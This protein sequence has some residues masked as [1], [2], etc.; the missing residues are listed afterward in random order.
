MI[1]GIG[2]DIVEI[3]RI[4]KVIEKDNKFIEKIF[5]QKE[6]DYCEKKFRKEQHYGARFAAKESFFKALGT[7]W[8]DGMKWKDISIR[9]DKLGKPKVELHGET[10][11]KIKYKQ[12]HLSISHTK[13]YAIAYV[14][15]E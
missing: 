1:K 13:E 12:I 6:I 9:N 8:R 7:G 2:I 4:K 14:I 11:K 3:K 5:T 10:F 15:I